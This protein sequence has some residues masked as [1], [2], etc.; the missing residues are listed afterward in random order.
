MN[1]MKNNSK[2][3]WNMV[4]FLTI[5]PL[6]GIFGTSIYVYYNGIVW[7]E[8]VLLLVFWFISG[9]GITM[10]Y[11]RLFAHKSFKT[12][13]FVE[14]ILMI[15]GSLAFE[16]TILKWV[17]DHR[18]HHNFSDTKD[19]PYS[20][21]EGFWHAHI[22]WIIKNTPEKQSRIKGVKD[23][24]SKP[25]IKFQNKY[26]FHIG[27]IVGF[28]LP[29][30]VGLIYDRPLGAVLWAG[31][32]RVTLVH[33]ATFFINSLCHFVG[34]RPYDYKSS[35]RDSWFVSLFTFGEGYHN[36][37]HTF[38]WD[39]R[40]GVKWFAFDPSKWIIKLLSFIGI[41]YDLRETKEYLIW[42]NHISSIKDQLNESYNKSTE[43]C[44]H[45]YQ[46]KIDLLQKNI[47][48]IFSS[49]DE[50]EKKYNNLKNTDPVNFKNLI[51]K[52]KT[53]RKKYMQELKEIKSVLNSIKFNI[54]KN[55]LNTK[56]IIE[57]SDK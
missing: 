37:H 11:H 14:W 22:G 47:D 1:Q 43:N 45:F 34:N 7:Q 51:K 32:L 8:P 25:A 31:F 3:N 57:G 29:L 39:Y 42:K 28:I 23:L 40:N 20:I 13:S 17:S 10:G 15:F 18:K 12:N 2:Y 9:M 38:Q 4:F 54:N 49:W 36:Y 50:M 19:D 48:N 44:K 21:M 30:I 56:L 24:E 33:H 53:N 5:I 16:N 41:T 35:A 26:Y 52:L 27:I 55:Y 6:I 46:N